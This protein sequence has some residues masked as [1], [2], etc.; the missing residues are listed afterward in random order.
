MISFTETITVKNDFSVV[1]VI[2]AGRKRYME[3]LLPQIMREQEWI[4]EIRFCVNTNVPEDLEW[5]DAQAAFNPKVKL[6]ERLGR[7]PYNAFELRGFWDALQE[8]QTIY[9]RLDDDVIW[10]KPGFIKS[11]LDF[12]V[13][14]F[15][16]MFVYP[17]LIN[18]GITDYIH[19]KMGLLS[20]GDK[21]LTYDYRD[22][23]AISNPEVAIEKHKIFLHHLAENRLNEYKFHKWVLSDYEK[24]SINS[25]CWFGR[26]MAGVEVAPDEETHISQAIPLQ[27][28]RPN[29]ING[30]TLAVHFAFHTQREALEKTNLLEQ[31]RGVIL[32]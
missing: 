23:L 5:L 32:E 13:T 30:G 28:N 21:K 9:I 27:K 31:Y 29:V 2:P 3:L 25:L 14:N 12:R 1:V 6:D 4:D 11:M 20:M 18:N 19:Q 22:D 16:P 8:S 15:E 10:L 26:D 7:Q 24:M 17:N